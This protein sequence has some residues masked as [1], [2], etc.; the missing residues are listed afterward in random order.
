MKKRLS[1]Q[2]QMDQARRREH[3]RK[4]TL[5][6]RECYKWMRKHLPEVYAKLAK[7]AGLQKT[8]RPKKEAKP[9]A[10]PRSAR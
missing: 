5:L 3:N 2:E 6:R 7:K 8:V 4:H 10:R 1:V 9:V